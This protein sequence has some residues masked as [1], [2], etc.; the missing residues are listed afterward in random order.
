[1]AR[2]DIREVGAPGGGGVLPH[3]EAARAALAVIH[4]VLRIENIQH[5]EAAYGVAVAGEVRVGFASA[6]RDAIGDGGTLIEMDR[7]LFQLLVFDG[8]A[9]GNLGGSGAVSHGLAWLDRLCGEISAIGFPSTAGPL[10]IWL[11]GKWIDAV[12]DERPLSAATA[13]CY[14]GDQAGGVAG[15]AARYRADMA[16]VA[17]CIDA[18]EAGDARGAQRTS[19]AELHLAWQPVCA[20]Q[21]PTT[22]LYREA[23][24]RVVTAADVD[25]S[26]HD[27]IQAFERLG[28]AAL[29]D[30]YVVDRVIGELERSP[31]VVLGVNISAQSA[32]WNADWESLCERF[33]ARPGI[34]S[35]L[36][37]E[38]TET[39]P[40]ADIGETV[41][42]VSRMR[43]VGC[44]IAVDD[45]GV[46]YASIRQLLALT[47]D[48]VKIDHVFLRRAV[49]SK[50]GLAT[51]THMIA[52]ARS[53]AP[54]VIVE[55]I[56]DEVDLQLAF[57]AGAEWQQGYHFGRPTRIRPWRMAGRREAEAETSGHSAT[58]AKV[59][60][61]N[62]AAQLR[63]GWAI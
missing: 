5:I 13:R 4:A 38:V 24:L 9:L 47:P 21:D 1:M 51:L 40:I 39:A 25:G 37:L 28:F 12:G 27:T 23:L 3:L 56:E 20:A 57:G 15:W 45:F 26:P 43:R 22:V 61:L 14:L 50:A 41:R 7:G 18:I 8:D 2:S 32:R 52:L 19:Q 60:P 46:G 58:G 63:R 59:I 42:F 11:S 36:I 44:R 55:G 29:L 53:I 30:R 54:T 48:I 16:L 34:A 62:R 35:R 31:D 10:H 6:L 49:A 17:G 33:A